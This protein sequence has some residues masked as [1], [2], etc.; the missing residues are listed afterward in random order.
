MYYFTIV[1]EFKTTILVLTCL[2]LLLCKFVIV[3]TVL[4]DNIDLSLMY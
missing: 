3:L 4:Y 2:E 1:L